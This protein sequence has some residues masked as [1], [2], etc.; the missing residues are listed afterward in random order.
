MWQHYKHLVVPAA[1]WYTIST[2]YKHLFVPAC[3]YLGHHL[4]N[5]QKSVSYDIKGML[6]QRGPRFARVRMRAYRCVHTRTHLLR[7]RSRALSG[8]KK[9]VPCPKVTMKLTKVRWRT[10]PSVLPGL[11]RL[12]AP[13]GIHNYHLTCPTV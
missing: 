9:S 1:C 4:I 5:S 8:K 7:E 2:H 13:N 6:A 10:L 3:T 12:T 11:L